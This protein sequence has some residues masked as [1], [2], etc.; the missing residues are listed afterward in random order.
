MKLTSQRKNQE[1]FIPKLVSLGLTLQEAAIYAY[2]LEKKQTRVKDIASQ[3]GIMI[4]AVHR[5]LRRLRERGFVGTYGHPLR[6]EGINPTICLGR[7]LEQREKRLR[8]TQKEI[9]D[10]YS[11]KS[12]AVSGS[13]IEYL[14]NKAETLLAGIARANQTEKEELIISVGEPI[15]QDLYLAQTKALQRGVKIK[16]IVEKLNAENRELLNNWQRAGWEVRYHKDAPIHLA[17]FDGK[18]SI[19]MLKR[20]PEGKERIGITFFSESFSQVLRDYFYRLWE[21]S[22]SL[23]AN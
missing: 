2:V 16:L 11:R 15:P 9:E 7:F 12:N 18:I 14:E 21:K 8:S 5:T 1:G 22:K 3:L 19:L 20:D 6:V 4:P 17:I 10:L 23:E 13:E